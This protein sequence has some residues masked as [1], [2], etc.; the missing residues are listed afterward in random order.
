[1][2]LFKLD[3]PKLLI[4]PCL[5]FPTE[6]PVKPVTYWFPFLSVFCPVTTLVCLLCGP[7]WCAVP[8]VSGICKYNKLCSSEPSPL[9]HVVAIPD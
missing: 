2:E 5:A 4:F 3:N 7:L 8:S 9:S 1:M 6:T